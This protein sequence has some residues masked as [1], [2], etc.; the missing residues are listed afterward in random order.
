M[1]SAFDGRNCEANAAFMSRSLQGRG[2]IWRYSA[3]RPVETRAGSSAIGHLDGAFG[4][5][6]R[7]DEAFA[8]QSR[9][10]LHLGPGLERQPLHGG[11]CAKSM[12]ERAASK[13]IGPEIVEMNLDVGQ[14]ATAK[15][16]PRPQSVL[17]A[18]EAAIGTRPRQTIRQGCRRPLDQPTQRGPNAGQPRPSGSARFGSLAVPVTR[19]D[20]RQDSRQSQLCFRR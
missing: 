5:D 7:N 6:V 12:D 1:D 18:H 16:G 11:R 10:C 8:D 4:P 20:T 15:P 19:A 2:G 13:R 3:R 14:T 17:D 9:I